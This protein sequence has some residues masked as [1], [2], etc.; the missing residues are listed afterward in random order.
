M[1]ES[2]EQQLVA[3]SHEES[4]SGLPSCSLIFRREARSLLSQSMASDNKMPLE[5]NTSKRR[6]N[7]G[8]IE[9]ELAID[10]LFGYVT[11]T[12]VESECLLLL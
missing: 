4:S 10:F 2:Q 11:R 6:G 3:G 5:K 1:P 9:L 8:A 12:L 7:T